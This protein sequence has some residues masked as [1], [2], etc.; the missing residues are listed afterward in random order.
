M[1]TLDEH[2]KIHQ[3]QTVKEWFITT[4]SHT[5][6]GM[7]SAVLKLIGRLWDVLE[8]TLQ[9]AGLLCCQYKILTKS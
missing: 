2:V 6:I 3:A 5:C 1:A 4:V 8:E 9:S 7:E